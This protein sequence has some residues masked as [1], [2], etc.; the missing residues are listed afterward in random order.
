MANTLLETQM[1]SLPL[2]SFIEGL[3]ISPVP[4]WHI[5]LIHRGGYRERKKQID[6]YTDVILLASAGD[7]EGGGG[8]LV[9]V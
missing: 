2:H 4:K 9:G 6:G 8:D 1:P 3:R 5:F 7:G